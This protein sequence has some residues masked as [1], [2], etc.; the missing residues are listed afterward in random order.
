MLFIMLP[1]LGAG[2]ASPVQATASALPFATHD[3]Q[4]PCSHLAHEH[5]KEG[6]ELFLPPLQEENLCFGTRHLRLIQPTPARAAGPTK[7]STMSAEMFS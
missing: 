3:L 7:Q 5:S 6:T 2:Q 4:V 1:L